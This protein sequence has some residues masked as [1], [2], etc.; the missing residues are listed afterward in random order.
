M[1]VS[2]RFPLRK[3]LTLALGAALGS[4]V[5]APALGQD[6]KYDETDMVLEEVI[7]TGSRIKRTTQTQSQEI[8][9][10]DFEQIQ[11]SGDISVAE[12]LRSS[13]LNSFGS[14]P[15][16]SG[17]VGQST[18][19]LDLRGLGPERNLVLL[20]SRRTVGSP[21]LWGG[22][23][24]NLNMIPFS[25][26]DRIEMIADGA[27]AVYGSDA[28]AGVTNVI[29]KKNYEGLLFQAR[30]GDRSEDDGTE[31][32]A[33]VLL[34]AGDGRRSL[35]IALEYDK[36]DP[37]Y[38][39]D[40]EYTRA[41]WGDYDGDGEIIGYEESVGVSFY[42]YTL[43]NPNWYPGI[44]YDPDDPGTWFLTPGAG[45][46]EGD[47]WA[48]VMRADNVA[49]PDSGYYCGYAFALV[50]ANR[51]GLERINSWVNASYELTDAIELYADVIVSQVESF[52]R[53][54]PPAANGPPIPGDPR[55]DIGATFGFYRFVEIGTRDTVVNDTLT[56][57]NL[58]ARGAFGDGVSW[59]AYYTY[60]DYVSVA[61]G[62]YFLSWAGLA[63]NYQYGVDDFETFVANIRTTTLND[64][65]QTL[66]KAFG[67]LQ[68]D[69]FE[70]P[71]GTVT[72]YAGAEYFEIDYAA[73]VDAQ[74]EA[75]LVGG[76]AGAS[77]WGYRDVTAVF[78]EAVVPL[79]DWWEVDLALR[80]DDYSDFGSSTTPRIGTVLQLPGY[81]ELRF[82]GSWGQGFRAP[83]LSDLF[84]TSLTE[85]DLAT[86]WYGCQVNGIAEDDCYQTLLET[87]YGANPDLSAET[88]ES[89]SLGAEWEF[90]D[91]WLASVSYFN[92][93]LD[94]RIVYP[95][96]QD[97]LDADY[98]GGGNNPNVQRNEL[99]WAVR[100]DSR[101]QNSYVP[102][103]YGG[104]DFAVGGRVS[105][106]AGDFGLQ[107]YL[108]WYLTYELEQTYGT[109][110]IYDATGTI[111]F[112]EW[113]ANALLTW[114][115]GD[116][117]AS[118]N[119]DYVA[120]QKDRVSG[121][122]TDPWYTFNLQAGYDFGRF[123][124]VTL[125]ANN[126]LNRGPSVD[127]N[128]FPYDPWYWIEDYTGRV[129][130]LSY[131]VER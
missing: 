94:D 19:T 87:S 29:L 106:R 128:G 109:G 75:G 6:T 122:Q 55:N 120:A 86:D 25:A 67:G 79:F 23:T 117:F 115:L 76:S 83:D 4:W 28:I 96:I 92:L 42:G 81:E 63:Y 72:A 45:C 27:S 24:V 66:Q 131:R 126:L 84:G 61:P 17:W 113:R 8:I 121:D 2:A 100:V 64:D 22:G 34:G 59:D 123:G 78:V 68:F 99:G 11:L 21:S 118:L 33:S 49:G 107:G 110:E 82:K 10:F 111:W 102:L 14:L 32:S 70:A 101:V 56:D 125:G 41:K 50:S 129:L 98:F 80:Y 90:A 7:V 69:L 12:A 38:D 91:R 3:T 104:I 57:I 43:I 18:A 47:G 119:C 58:G 15:E 116:A 62:N 53:Y 103:S 48:G 51:A 36:R 16:A 26:V 5:A 77:A 108:S 31:E 74:S 37:I 97:Q 40:R 112:P 124:T 46:P 35:T 60:S 13:T 73:L 88:S 85:F 54:A 65:R 93:E 20:N 44:Q 89:W 130:F 127:E 1:A 39:A 71:A 9:N 52:G 30:Y 105:T 95:L 114:E